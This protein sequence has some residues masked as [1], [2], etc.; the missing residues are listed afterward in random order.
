LA[1]KEGKRV[2]DAADLAYFYSYKAA[3]LFS[4]I[5]SELSKQIREAFEAELG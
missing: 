1:R 5:I 4:E 3:A 2:I